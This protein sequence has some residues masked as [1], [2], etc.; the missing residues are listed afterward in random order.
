MYREWFQKYSGEYGRA[1][2]TEENLIVAVVA[3]VDDLL[4]ARSDLDHLLSTEPWQPPPTP[5]APVAE[6]YAAVHA[7]TIGR[8]IE[9]VWRIAQR[10]AVEDGE[11]ETANRACLD[12]LKVFVSPGAGP[13]TI[14]ELYH[15]SPLLYAWT[16]ACA[17]LWDKGLNELLHRGRWR[18]GYI[19]AHGD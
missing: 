3:T 19:P 18:V 10:G 4:F 13:V 12:V 16:V 15:D 11:V 6:R 17:L 5:E 1:D 8:A 14:S 9:H 2:L 7:L